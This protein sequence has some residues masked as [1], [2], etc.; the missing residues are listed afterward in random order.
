MK[1]K[2]LRILNYTLAA[3]GPSF[4][5]LRISLLVGSDS[6][7]KVSPKAM[8]ASLLFC[9]NSVHCIKTFRRLE[10]YLNVL[11]LKNITRYCHC[12]HNSSN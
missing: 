5:R 2:K 6:A 10:N 7:L 12:Q 1:S 3:I 4:S 11:F 9:G 8:A